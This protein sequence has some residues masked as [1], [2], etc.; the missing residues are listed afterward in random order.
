MAGKNPLFPDTVEAEVVD[1]PQCEQ[2]PESL[3]AGQFMQLHIQAYDA[4]NIYVRWGDANGG[5][6]FITNAMELIRNVSDA[7]DRARKA[8]A[9]R[10]RAC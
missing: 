7:M 5:P 10:G 8:K 2:T 9:R 3:A 6:F 1:M 4:E